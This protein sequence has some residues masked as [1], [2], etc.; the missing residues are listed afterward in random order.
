MSVCL[1]SLTPSIF[2]SIF[3]LLV[4]NHLGFFIHNPSYPFIKQLSRLVTIFKFICAYVQVPNVIR[5]NVISIP[6]SVPEML[7]VSCLDV[8]GHLHSLGSVLDT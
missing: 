3:V 7:I 1:T 8:A 5:I 6:V 2:R 4:Q